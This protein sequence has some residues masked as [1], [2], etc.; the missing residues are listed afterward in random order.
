MHALMHDGA[1][2]LL[3]SHALQQI[4]RFCD[5]TIW[6]ET[7]EVVMRGP[8]SEVIK[9]Y[10]KFTRELDRTW[11][12]QQQQRGAEHAARDTDQP[13]LSEWTDLP[14]LR[15]GAV[16]IEDE[17]GQEQG[18]FEVGSRCLVRVRVRAEDD[19][20][21]PI[22][23]VA[24][25]FRPDGLVVTRHI[26]PAETVRM[27]KGD[28]FEATLDLGNLPFGNGDYLLSVGVWAHVDPKHIEPSTYY[29][30][31]DR[32]F[33]FQVVGNPPMNNELFVHPG[34]WRVGPVESARPTASPS[35]A[36]LSK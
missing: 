29:H 9:A 26:G 16:T 27:K 12:R 8:T 6:L 20:R 10:E 31:L 30:N 36:K 7:G 17:T 32:S 18:V 2:V 13:S 19:G 14:G 4:Q 23:L 15:V 22:V 5:E 34:M 1:S 11:L 25:V 35:G 33:K 24:L 3:V 28:E 21:Y